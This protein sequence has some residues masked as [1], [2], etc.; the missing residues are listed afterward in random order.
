[1]RYPYKMSE[2]L[3][4]NL[5]W[6][7]KL[8]IRIACLYNDILCKISRK[9]KYRNYRNLDEVIRFEDVKQRGD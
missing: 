4:F 5:K 2:V 3:P 1:M 8:F 9:Y 6:Y 7:Q